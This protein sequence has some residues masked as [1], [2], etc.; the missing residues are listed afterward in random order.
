VTLGKEDGPLLFLFVAH[1]DTVDVGD[2]TQW[3]HP[4]FA[5]ETDGQR[6]WAR[7]ACDNKGGIAVALYAMRRLQVG[8]STRDLPSQLMVLPVGSG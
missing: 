7:G 6:L 3:S 8:E 1:A 2:T 5:G 4:P